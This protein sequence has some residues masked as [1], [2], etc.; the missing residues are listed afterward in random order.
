MGLLPCKWIYS[1]KREDQCCVTR[2]SLSSC[3][4]LLEECDKLSVCMTYASQMTDD[5]IEHIEI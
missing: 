4:G 5:S 2:L 3:P 1:F